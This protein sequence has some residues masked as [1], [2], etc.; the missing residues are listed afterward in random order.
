MI[1]SMVTDGKWLNDSYIVTYSHSQILEMPSHLNISMMKCHI[2]KY[3]NIY[4]RQIA[5]NI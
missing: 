2:A 1:V 5:S 4:D 3:Q